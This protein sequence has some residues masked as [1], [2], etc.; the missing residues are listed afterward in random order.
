MTFVLTSSS[1]Q[2]GGEI[3]SCFTCD[4]EDKTPTLSW[5]GA[6]KGTKSF[7]LTCDDPDVPETLRENV[8][9][10]V[11]DHWVL[12]NIP[13][14][15]TE[16]RENSP[17]GPDGSHCGTNSWG[18]QDWGG[19]CPPNP[20]AHRYFF[21]LYALDTLLSLDPAANKKALLKAMDGHVLAEACLMG[22]YLKQEFR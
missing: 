22:T 21:K 4:G 15:C 10:L 1:F 14:T 3:P 8:P 17:T 19:P 18:R 12:F 7:A 6:P 11:W 9:D 16:I 20:S 5:R 13:P 2:N